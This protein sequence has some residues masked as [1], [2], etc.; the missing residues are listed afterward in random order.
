M[1]EIDDFNARILEF[2][3]LQA[4]LTKMLGILREERAKVV[5]NYV[6]SFDLEISS[7]EIRLNSAE[8]DLRTDILE[9]ILSTGEVEPHPAVHFRRTKKVMYDKEEVLNRARIEGKSEFLREKVELDVRAFEK[10]VKDG[11]ID[12]AEVEIVNAPTIALDKL[13]DLVIAYEA[14]RE[15]EQN[16]TNP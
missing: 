10:A 5:K 1:P 7:L 14:G 15:R 13:G 9:H 16:G 4:D 8:T 2:A 3:L 12:W 6:E 11:E